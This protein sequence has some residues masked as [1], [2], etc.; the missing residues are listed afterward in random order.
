MRDILALQAEVA[1]A[2]ATQIQVKVTP[3]EQTRLAHAPAVDPDAYEAHLRGRYLWHRRTPGAMQK[4]IQSFEEA[5]A[6]DP[7]FAA[8]HAGL[9]DCVGWKG[10]FGFVAPAE[11]CGRAKALALRALEIDPN[12]AEAHASLAWAVQYYDYD[13]LTAEKEFRHAIDLDPRSTVAHSRLAMT[14]GFVGRFDESI[15]EAEYSVSLDPLFVITGTLLCWN[16][17]V[18]RRFDQQIAQAKKTL[19]LHPGVPQCH[20]ALGAAY[21]ETSD[22]DAAIAQF[23]VAV[24]SSGRTP[25]YLALLAEA[26]AV[27]GH[28]DDAEAILAELL[29]LS[30]QQYVT[31]YMIGRIYAALDSK[32]EAFRWLEIAYGQRAALMVVLKRDPRLDSLQSDPR[33][34]ALVGR[35]NYP[36]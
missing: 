14:L 29:G 32:D 4:A 6:R 20:Y 23:Q 13:F 18:A 25:M 15:A 11:G 2:I 22:F 34:E 10:W 9:S 21:L 28:R 12:L 26:Y 1:S 19:E 3:R 33:F 8:A 31:P 24:E 27:A 7:N 30:L 16:C 17:W 35:M 5:I 36:S